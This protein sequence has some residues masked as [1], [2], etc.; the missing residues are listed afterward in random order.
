M[1]R[2]GNI[3]I[4]DDDPDVLFSAKMLLKDYYKKVQ[5]VAIPDSFPDCWQYGSYD[6][7]LLDMNYRGS[8]T[9]GREGLAWLKKIKEIDNSVVVVMMTAY[10]T[11]DIAIETIEEGAADFIVKPWHNEK[12][13]ATLSSALE[14]RKSKQE[15]KKLQSTQRHSMTIL[16][17]KFGEFIGQSPPMLHLYSDH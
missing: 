8:E 15:V 7:V 4:V 11:V 10:V 12:L 2:E 14:L 6:L 16:T 9:S 13:I 5:T 17:K 1:K 3:L